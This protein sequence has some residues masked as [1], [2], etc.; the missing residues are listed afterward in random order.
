MLADGFDAS[1]YLALEIHTADDEPIAADLR[2]I[3]RRLG[4][5]LA[6]THPIYCLAPGEE[7]RL[8]LLAAIRL[9]CALSAVPAEELPDEGNAR[10]RSSW[11]DPTD[12]SS[13]FAAF[14]EALGAHWM[15]L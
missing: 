11:P 13:R 8:R 5:G 1:A 14:P 3:A 15:A 4:I 7:S 6:G 10:I 9:N 2:A 12:Y